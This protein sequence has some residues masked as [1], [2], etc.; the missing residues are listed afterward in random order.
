MGKSAL[1]PN[2]IEVPILLFNP[3]G[4]DFYSTYKE[5]KN[6]GFFVPINDFIN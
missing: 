1:F 6:M 5:I 3:L 2:G 4:V